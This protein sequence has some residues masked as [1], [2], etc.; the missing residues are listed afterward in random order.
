MLLKTRFTYYIFFNAEKA[1]PHRAELGAEPDVIRPHWP[2]VDVSIW[3]DS[4]CV[5]HSNH[6]IALGCAE[7]IQ[8]AMKRYSWWEE[9]DE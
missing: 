8:H 5:S 9:K 4:I 7:Q 2:T 3:F 1:A 6:D